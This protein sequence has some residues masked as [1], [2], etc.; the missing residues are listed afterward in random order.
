MPGRD[1]YL[2]GL[3]ADGTA[4]TPGITP[5]AAAGRGKNFAEDEPARRA[6]ARSRDDLAAL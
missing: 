2:D 1:A 3:L 5:R 4:A 6:L